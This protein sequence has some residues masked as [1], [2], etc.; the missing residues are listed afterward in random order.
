MDNKEINGLEL[1]IP[2]VNYFQDNPFEMLLAVI[3]LIQFF[4]PSDYLKLKWKLLILGVS[5]IITFIITT[6]KYIIR[7]GRFY[8]DY[9][10]QYEHFVNKYD[11]VNINSKKLKEIE[12]NQLQFDIVDEWKDK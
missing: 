7:N 8:K 12:D 4:V 3:G 9:E 5:F 11:I 10:K 6:V 2:K 1:K